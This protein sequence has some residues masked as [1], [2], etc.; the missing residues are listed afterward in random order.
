MR[1]GTSSGCADGAALDLQV[2]DQARAARALA[3]DLDVGR[4]QHGLAHFERF[5][6]AELALQRL[7][8]LRH[9]QAALADRLTRLAARSG[10]GDAWSQYL[11]GV[12][13]DEERLRA[14]LAK[15]Q[16]KPTIPPGMPIELLDPA[17]NEPATP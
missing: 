14:E 1:T 16:A 7:A 4:R 17:Q 6:R 9:L 11:A 13:G 3:A 8:R 10:K 15:R 2:V 12:L 5:L